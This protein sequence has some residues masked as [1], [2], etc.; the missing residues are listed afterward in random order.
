MKEQKILQRSVMTFSKTNLPEQ[1]FKKL[2]CYAVF[3]YIS[4]CCIKADHL[5]E[6]QRDEAFFDVHIPFCDFRSF[7]S[8]SCI[9]DRLL[10]SI[11]NLLSVW[12]INDR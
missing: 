4:P 9:T 2:L 3:R 1:T 11:I 10:S 12:L 7:S 6:S 8:I 5:V